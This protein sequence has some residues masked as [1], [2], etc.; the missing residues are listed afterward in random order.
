[1]TLLTLL[2]GGESTYNNVVGVDQ[3]STTL[4]SATQQYWAQRRTHIEARIAR[5]QPEASETDAETIWKKFC[6]TETGFLS[7]ML[8]RAINRLEDPLRV[9][10]NGNKALAKDAVRLFKAKAAIAL[11]LPF[12]RQPVRFVVA[13][14]KTHELEIRTSGQ[15]DDGND[16]QLGKPYIAVSWGGDCFFVVTPAGEYV[17]MLTFYIDNPETGRWWSDSVFPSIFAQTTKEFA[18]DLQAVESRFA[19]LLDKWNRESGL[20][21]EFKTMQK[22]PGVQ[23]TW[24][25]IH[26]PEAQKLEILKAIDLFESGDP[27]APHG[28]LLTG[29]PGVGKSLLGKTIAETV[30]CTFQHLT[31]ASLKLDH[32]GGS[33]QRVREIWEKARREQPSILYLDECEGVLGRRGSAE[34]DAI[35]A[36]I[37]QAFLAEWDGLSKSDRVLVIGATNRRDLLDDA[38]LSRFGWE[39]Q[40]KLPSEV[41]RICILEQELKSVGIDVSLPT[42]FASRTQGLSGREIQEVART[43]RRLAHPELPTLEQ[44]GEAINR[45]RKSGNISVPAQSRWENLVL[46]QKLLARLKVISG[47]LRD[48][49]KWSAEGIS[50]PRTLLLEGLAGGG[51]TE[52][53]RTLAN[54]SG[55]AFF[56]AT[57]A[58]IK[59]NYLGQSGNRVKQ[60]FERARAHAPC[61]LFL[62]ELDIVAPDRTLG[63]DDPLT[64]EIVGQ[65]LQ[66]VDGVEAHSEHV[67]LL[68]A[69]NRPEAVDRAIL[70]RFTEHLRVP[71]PDHAARIRLL[72][73]LL[74]GK[75][76]DFSMEAGTRL[77]ADLTEGKALSGRDLKSWVASAEQSALARVFENG[78][79]EQY[80]ITLDD[81]SAAS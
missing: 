69:T 24:S 78:G 14:A 75:K 13:S 47:L 67:F 32:L 23:E 61:I 52:I 34:A 37:V 11:W 68:G 1:M 62:D 45:L 5:L 38:I 36:E 76:L 50:I 54:E 63:E 20:K 41:D 17:T 53:G 35:S 65:L 58:D 12:S 49:E 10:W 39:M 71:L 72:T 7:R 9:H 48:A 42:D 60:V 27:A 26:I 70:S 31:P 25:R 16:F 15:T 57:T 33:G 81:F 74:T 21:Q 40:I 18:K 64:R 80:V 66:E 22:L 56:S 55:L 51:K 2:E 44:I 30:G 29:P 3:E 73:I 59:A 8:A 4:T 79:P 28:L 6:A 43:A 19:P 77:L 46:D